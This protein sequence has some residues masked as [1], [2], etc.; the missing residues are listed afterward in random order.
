MRITTLRNQIIPGILEKDWSQ[1]EAKIESVKPFSNFI[2]ID[3]IDGIFA[4]NTTFLDPS[5]FEKYRNDFFM[6]AHLMVDNPLSYLDNFAKYGF[7]RFIGQIE[8]MQNL[9]EFVARAE[10]LGE[11]GLAVDLE[12]PIEAILDYLEDLDFIFLMSVKA[13]FSNQTFSDQVL[14]KIKKI[15]QID[16]LIPIEIDGGINE[17]TLSQAF[18]IGANRFVS[19]KAIFGSGNPKENFLNLKKIIDEGQGLA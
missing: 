13:G 4:P 17:A 9:D 10:N 14:D 3:L 6:E 18:K 8:K 2:H 12:T 1:I 19:T 7:K 11:V 16:D 15:R 5:F